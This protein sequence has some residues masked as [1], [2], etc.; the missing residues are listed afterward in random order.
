MFQE[1]L[2]SFRAMVDQLNPLSKGNVTLYF[3]WLSLYVITAT[4]VWRADR[5][6]VRG[7]CFVLNQVFSVGVLISLLNVV[8]PAIYFWV[9]SIAT[10]VVAF[11]CTAFLCRRRK[12]PAPDATPE[13]ALPPD[14]TD[15][16]RLPAPPLA[17]PLVLPRVLPPPSRRGGGG[18]PSVA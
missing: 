9:E 7:I 13:T 14:P 2:G 10:A 1:L 5:R 11:A 6:W 16:R 12:K 15:A 18:G 8:V 4:A 3:V 17:P